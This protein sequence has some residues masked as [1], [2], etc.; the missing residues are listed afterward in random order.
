MSSDTCRDEA[1]PDECP[2]PCDTCIDPGDCEDCLD[3]LVWPERVV[4]PPMPTWT[5]K[6]RT[7]PVRTRELQDVRD[8]LDVGRRVGLALRRVRR[9]GGLSQTAL[10]EQVGWPASS[11]SRAEHDASS[12]PLG[13]VDGL[14]RQVG[15][16][17]AV[18]EDDDE[19]TA[20]PGELPDKVWGT[21]DLLARDRR[22]RRFPPFARLTWEDPLDRDLYRRHTRQ[23]PE[24]TWQLP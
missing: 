11:L 23:L 24:W 21:A 15:H 6:A 17:L 3:C 19:P 1:S 5:P 20:A 2:F 14:L 8:R 12:I 22:G 10:A 18:V 13:K 4:D 9:K 7:S 16:R